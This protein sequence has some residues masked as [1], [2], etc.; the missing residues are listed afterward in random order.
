VFKIFLK[1]YSRYNNKIKLYYFL[2]SLKKD[3]DERYSAYNLLKLDFDKKTE[4][5]SPEIVELTIR[6]RLIKN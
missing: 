6:V 3:H 2:R 5:I 4:D 1:Y